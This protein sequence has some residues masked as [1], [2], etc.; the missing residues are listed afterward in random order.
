MYYNKGTRIEFPDAAF[1]RK[2][3]TLIIARYS[4]LDT[5]QDALRPE[6]SSFDVAQARLVVSGTALN[7]HFA[8][9]IQADLLGKRDDV[10]REPDLR[11]ASIDWSPTPSFSLRIG[12]SKL[13]CPRS[14]L[15]SD[16][17]LQFPIRTEAALYFD[18]GRQA[19]AMTSV[20]LLEGLARIN[21][22]LFNGNSDN[23]GFNR[24]GLDTHHLAQAGVRV[25]AFGKMNFLEEGD[26]G[27]TPEPALS[28]GTFY[29]FNDA[30]I[31]LGVIGGP[32]LDAQAQPQ[33]MLTSSIEELEFTNST[34]RG[35]RH[36]RKS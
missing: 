19:R 6:T 2:I 25:I 26:V 31:Q 27:A 36:S 18:E 22:A 16:A 34:S 35:S 17:R 8:N 12:Q 5:D 20:D 29:G 3:N 24:S 1:D 9:L 13:L 32:E 15:N 33:V 28:I 11:D 23:E 4:F 30:H 21:A 10:R 7:K 14:G